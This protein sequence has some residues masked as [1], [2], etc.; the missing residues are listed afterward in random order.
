MSVKAGARRKK[1]PPQLMIRGV[2]PGRAGSAASVC[3]AHFS[4][5]AS[6][7]VK[8]TDARCGVFPT[9]GKDW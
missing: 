8:R 4:R 1:A 9:S 3:P 2:S 6:M 5:C 7:R